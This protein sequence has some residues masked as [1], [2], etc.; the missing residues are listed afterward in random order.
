MSF[1]NNKN[2][3]FKFLKKKL[4]Y[5]I[6]LLAILVLEGYLLLVFFQDQVTHLSKSIYVEKKI[7]SYFKEISSFNHWSNWYP[8]LKKTKKIT[9]FEPSI[10]GQGGYWKSQEKKELLKFTRVLSNQYIEMLHLFPKMKNQVWE[11]LAFS[12]IKAN[13]ITWEVHYQHPLS[14]KWLL[15]TKQE[16]K[17]L[18]KYLNSSINS[19]STIKIKE[20]PPPPPLESKKTKV[21][22]KKPKV[23]IS[24]PLP[25]KTNQKK[26]NQK[27]F[28]FF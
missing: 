7:E 22:S 20:I 19:L 1:N 16:K 5:L 6:T 26:T 14:S 17:Q 10:I 11:S 9:F 15:Q 25:K 2:K 27:P 21:D 3:V 12:K 23:K 24:P 13:K 4:Y 28:L 18:E 8:P